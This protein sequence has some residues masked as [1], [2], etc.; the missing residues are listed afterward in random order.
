MTTIL[1]CTSGDNADLFPRVLELYVRPGAVVADVTYG[2]GVFWR[3]IPSGTYKL[4]A[5]DLLQDKI[6][7][8]RLPYGDE[9]LDA[10]VMD[11]PYMNGGSGA[12]ESLNKCY[13][14]PGFN[15]YEAVYRL[16]MRGVL[17]AHRVLKKKAVLIIKCQ[18]CVADHVQKPIHAHLIAGLPPLGFRFDDEFVLHSDAKPIMRHGTQQHA[19]K[20]HSYFLVFTKVR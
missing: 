16:Y 10:E 8:T 1:T 2:K 14:N 11:P 7:F 6:D 12:K 4:L 19:R 13:K 15:S 5:T 18:P 9:S 3:N 20:N 17:E